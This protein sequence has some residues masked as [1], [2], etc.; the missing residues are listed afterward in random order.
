MSEITVLGFDFGEWKIGV[1]VGQTLTA[2][3]T[4]L[5]ILK[6]PN[7]KPDWEA[8]AKLIEEWQPGA[9][10]VGIPLNMYDEEQVMTHAARRFSRQLH[11]R[12]NL[13]VHEA[14]ERLSSREAQN[15]VGTDKQIDDIAAQIILQGWLNE[16][17]TSTT[18]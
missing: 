15:Q 11:G 14:D 17:Q 12:F 16:Y 3:A 18:R 8:I 6:S 7:K 13:P 4:G 9:L 2:T 10:V 1:A 5:K